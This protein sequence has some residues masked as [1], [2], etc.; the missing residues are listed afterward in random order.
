MNSP[1]QRIFDAWWPDLPRY[2]G[3]LPAKGTLA[4][5][6]IVIENLKED[7][8]LSLES[9]TASGGSQIRGVGRAALNTILEAHGEDRPFLKE[10]GRT[11]RGLRG[12]VKKL[13]GVISKQSLEKLPLKARNLVLEELQA[14]LVEKV[15]EYF[16][17]EKIKVSYDPTKT[18]RQMVVELLES[19]SVDG[20]SGQLAEYLVGAKLELRFPDHEIDNKPFSSADQPRGVKGDFSIGDAVF[21]VTV[22]PT[23]G[24]YEKCEENIKE[25]LY[26]YLLTL[27]ESV[28]AARQTIVN[29]SYGNIAVESIESFVAQNLDELSE[30]SKSDAEG[31][32]LELLTVYNRRVDEV[33]NDKSLLIEIPPNLRGGEKE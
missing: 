24:H 25:G 6:L 11:N 8:D 29:N 14:L 18:T 32:L 27:G 10:A 33:E 12:A 21:H 23:I 15:R 16:S 17:L 19:A 26:P 9:H 3:N 5:T 7:F 1:A 22:S 2:A 31:L 4:G 30:F 13:L 28:S 20:K